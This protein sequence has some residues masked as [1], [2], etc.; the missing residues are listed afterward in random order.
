MAVTQEFEDGSSIK[1]LDDG[2]VLTTDAEG[3]VSAT[4]KPEGYDWLEP[5]SQASVET[6]P[7][8]PYNHVIQSEGGHTIELDDTKNQERIRIQHSRTNDESEGSFVEWQSNG[9]KVDKIYGNGYEI[10]AKGKYVEING[11]C[12]ITIN[13]DSVVHVK[14]DKYELIDGDFIQ[15]IK[16]S[17][18]QS[19]AKK[20]SIICE[21]DLN[22]GCGDPATGRLKLSVGDHLY[23]KGDLSV[24]GSIVGN[25]VTAKTKVNGG[26]QVTAGPLGFV[27]EA[28]GL[29][30]GSAV[31][32]PLNI[33]CAMSSYN[34]VSVNAGVA[35]NAPLINGFIVRDALS[36]MMTMRNIY[37]FHSH[38]GVKPG[39]GITLEP[40]EPML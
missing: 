11:V 33:V 15:Q 4:T 10:V 23:L 34:G 12:N 20:S 36:D 3:N 19:I 14:G 21:D 31:A 13:G 32:L 17:L 27:S 6:P 28:G 38:P 24:E 39:G 2:T 9:D 5:E 25:M 40:I 1:L 29:A 8:Y 18:T 37:N 22:I 16:G 7:K 35:V 26:T 30:I